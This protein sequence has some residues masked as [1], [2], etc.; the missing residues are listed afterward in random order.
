MTSFNDPLEIDVLAAHLTL[1]IRH[2]S[3]DAIPPGPP[4]VDD[5]LLFGV[6]RAALAE[7]PRPEMARYARRLA[8]EA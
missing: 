8:F 2:Q 5:R 1:A 7:T 4:T 3:F 6:L